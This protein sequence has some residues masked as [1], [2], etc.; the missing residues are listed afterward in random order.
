MI[1]QYS[2]INA[3]EKTT[4]YKS[5]T[6]E[7]C[8]QEA[9]CVLAHFLYALRSDPNQLD[10]SKNI[11]VKKW[12]E[13]IYFSVDESSEETFQGKENYTKIMNS[14]NRD[15]FFSDKNRGNF[16]IVITDSIER[17]LRNPTYAK[18]FRSVL[19]DDRILRNY[20]DISSKRGDKCYPV[21]LRDPK[22]GNATFYY[23][24]FIQKDHPSIKACVKEAVYHGFG[25]SSI[26]NSPIF[27]NYNKDGPY[28]KLEILL[29]IILYQNEIKVGVDYKELKEAFYLVYEPTIKEIKTRG[30]LNDFE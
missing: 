29:L 23:F 21:V 10:V 20:I 11:D 15:I 26:A 19:P 28:T 4:P 2:P 6:Q 17:S 8:I 30:L 7:E 9:K 14:I 24:A 27:L 18:I 13:E 25:L 5:T 12:R 3:K 16:N 22:L 1:L